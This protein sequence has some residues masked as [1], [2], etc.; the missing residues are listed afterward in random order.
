LV[1]DDDDDLREMICAVLED[2]GYAT[3]A[4]PGG[5]SALEYL[6]RVEP[7]D[8]ILLDLMM[9]EV[10]GFEFLERIR[11]DQTLA[12]LP[13]V[14]LTAKDLT[15]SERNFL[16]ERTL[17]VLSKNAQPIGALGKALSAI[18]SRRRPVQADQ[19]VH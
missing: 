7:P 14:V 5:E 17:L 10:D 6:G 19:T 11:S 4:M 16:A 8:L 2:A 3:V 1:I 15:E 18:A 9:P 12:G 13:V